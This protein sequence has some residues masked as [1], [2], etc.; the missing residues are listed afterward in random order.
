MLDQSHNSRAEV[1]AMVLS[2][3]NVQTAYAKALLVTRALAERQRAGDVLLG[4][5][6][7]FL[8]DAFETDC[9][10]ILAAT[11]G[12]NSAGRRSLQ[13]LRG[14]PPC[15]SAGWLREKTNQAP[16][17]GEGWARDGVRDAIHSTAPRPRTLA[18]D[19]RRTAPSWARGQRFRAQRDGQPFWLKASGRARRHAPRPVRVDGHRAKRG[20]SGAETLTDEQIKD[21]AARRACVCERP[22]DASTEAALTPSA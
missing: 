17:G 21:A 22:L 5:H 18:G 4:R 19:R 16:G 11:R 12:R 2:V 9:R 14:T 1:E 6:A 13:A 3:L 15:A 20:H 7:V 10:P 8:R